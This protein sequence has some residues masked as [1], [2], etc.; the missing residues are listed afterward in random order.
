[1]MR[2][3]FYGVRG[4]YAVPGKDTVE[5]GGN[6]TCVSVSSQRGKDQKVTRV[7]LDAGT[8]II[9]LGKE[10]MSNISQKKEVSPLVLLISH[11]HPDH[12]EGFTF[13]APNFISGLPINLYG[14]ESIRTHIG[15]VFERNMQPPN[16]PIE[17][18]E[19]KSKR[20]HY[21]VDTGHVLFVS[22]L[23]KHRLYAGCDLASNGINSPV[24][25]ANNDDVFI[26]EVMH[27]FGPS[28]PKDGAMYYK[29]TDLVSHK[30]VACIWDHESKIGGD[31]AV[32]NFAKGVD[33]MIHDTQYTQEEYESDK[34]VVQ[35]FGHS[36]YE[37]A[38]ENARQAEVKH[39]LICTHFNPTH[40]DSKL[41]SIQKKLDDYVSAE[42]LPFY[43]EL[44]AEGREFI[45]S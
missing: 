37:M 33:V 40:T 12:R 11:L 41:E 34:F 15:K 14:M 35:G 38:V 4:S 6:T 31:K 45:I 20:T 2:I 16:Y 1:M 17:Y 19:L 26:V 5:Y 42:S 25:L 18:K 29:I 27:A 9:Q 43:I 24:S 32:V 22:E 36:T 3:K 23:G 30:K 13:F 44:A 28:H 39:A 21:V 7:I 10:I 8:G